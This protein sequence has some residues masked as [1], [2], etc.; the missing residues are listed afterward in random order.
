[1]LLSQAVREHL[2]D[3][4]KQCGEDK[5]PVEDVREKI[6]LLFCNALYSISQGEYDSS[7][8]ALLDYVLKSTSVCKDYS[9]ALY[10]WLLETY[11]GSEYF[12]ATHHMFRQYYH[13]VMN[14]SNI[15]ERYHR[16]QCTHASACVTLYVHMF[17]CLTASQYND[18][19]WNKLKWHHRLKHEQLRG[20]CNKSFALFVVK[21]VG[22][23]GGEEAENSIFRRL[24]RSAMDGGRSRRRDKYKQAAKDRFCSGAVIFL[25]HVEHSERELVRP[26]CEYACTSTKCNIC[27]SRHNQ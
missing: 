24:V 3:Q 9:V 21:L 13:E 23:A 14:T 17:I 10:R 7:R 26:T 1:V 20:K 11:F 18:V 5:T 16:G 25:E 27:A 4:V 19:L 8:Q 22:F 6:M 12:R 15:V 2:V